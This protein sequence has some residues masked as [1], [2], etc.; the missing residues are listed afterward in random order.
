M[1]H[2]HEHGHHGNA[3]DKIQPAKPHYPQHPEQQA[4]N[5]AQALAGRAALPPGQ[6][7]TQALDIGGGGI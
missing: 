1:N 5:T 7:I 4:T 2:S 3:T 6:S